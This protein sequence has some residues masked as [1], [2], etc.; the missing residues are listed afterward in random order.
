MWR[1]FDLSPLSTLLHAD[2]TL[3][4]RLDDRF[5]AA[6]CQITESIAA[7]RAPI[8]QSKTIDGI[9]R[10]IEIVIAE[11]S[12]P[13]ELHR[14]QPANSSCA[15]GLCVHVQPDRIFRPRWVIGMIW[16]DTD[17]ASRPIDRCDFSSTTAPAPTSLNA[18]SSHNTQ[19]H[20]TEHQ[21]EEITNQRFEGIVQSA[22]RGT[23]TARATSSRRCRPP[24][25]RRECKGC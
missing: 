19:S 16:S 10:T 7:F 22:K 23:N 9:Y 15:Q 3:Y 21:S 25:S 13:S 4:R 20:A 17:S 5:D 11:K 1:H 8:G 24:Q 12:E 18:R 14:S 6:Q 2:D